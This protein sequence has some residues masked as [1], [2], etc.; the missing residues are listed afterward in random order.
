MDPLEENP[1]D[2]FPTFNLMGRESPSERRHRVD[3]EDR[4]P[5][6]NLTEVE[7]YATRLF[8]LMPGATFERTRDVF[9]FDEGKIEGLVVLVTREA[10]ELR[11]ASL[12]WPHPNIP[13]RSSRLWKRVEWEGLTDEQLTTLLDEAGAARKAEFRTCRYCGHT[14]P[15]ERFDTDDCC[16]GCA[17]E[18]LGLI[19]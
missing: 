18:H 13:A 4:Y 12:E 5:A 14:R 15:P 16:D 10:V 3:P 6:Y 2:P 1:E 19:H 7:E 9:Q 8:R 11:L 17:P